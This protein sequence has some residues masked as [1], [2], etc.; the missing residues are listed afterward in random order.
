MQLYATPAL[1]GQGDVVESATPPTTFESLGTDK[2]RYMDDRDGTPKIHLD[3]QSKHGD[4]SVGTFP[5]LPLPRSGG[6]PTTSPDGSTD[7]GIILEPLTTSQTRTQFPRIESCFSKPGKKPVNKKEMDTTDL[8]RLV[9]DHIAGNRRYYSCVVCK[10][11]FRMKGHV[12]QHIKTVHRRDRKFP[13]PVPGC[14]VRLITRFARDQVC[15][16]IFRLFACTYIHLVLK[17][18]A[19]I[20]HFLILTILILLFLEWRQLV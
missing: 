6:I 9:S 13:C 18:F 7:K 14:E 2:E 20:I 15:Q 3:E 11:T 12:K 17:P 1:S 4:I 5:S 19:K 8:N 10:K 16:R